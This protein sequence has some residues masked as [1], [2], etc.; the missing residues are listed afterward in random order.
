M[1]GEKMENNIWS[2]IIPS[3]VTIIGFLVNYRILKKEKMM[4][5]YVHKNKEQLKKLI[6]IPEE[7]LLYINYFTLLC[8]NRKIDKV[9]FER[10]KKHI[11]S[12]VLCYGSEDAVKIWVYFEKHIYQGIDDEVCVSTVQVIA[13]LVLLLM[14]IKY[15]ITNV[16]TSPKVGYVDFTSDKMMETG[17]YEKSIEEINKIVDTLGLKDFLKITDSRMY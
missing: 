12:N 3:L 6:D 8:G 7:I 1:D 9:E 10:I 16:K 15:D 11:S 4:D 17:F 13:P 14:Q 2:V 5:T